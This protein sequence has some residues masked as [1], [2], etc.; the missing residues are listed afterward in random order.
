MGIPDWITVTLR[1]LTRRE[2]ETYYDYIVRIKQSFSATDIKI[3]DLAD[4][5]RDLPQGTMKDKYR[6]AYRL[7]SGEDPPF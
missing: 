4:N 3:V 6:F 1:I 2:D 7:L 5:G